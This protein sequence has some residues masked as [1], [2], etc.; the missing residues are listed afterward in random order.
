MPYALDLFSPA[1]T[2]GACP[3]FERGG[4]RAAFSR[5]ALDRRRV[6]NYCA[7]EDHD[8]CPFYLS[9][10]LRSTRLRYCGTRPGDFSG[11]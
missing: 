4:C 10:V 8:L 6:Q 1:A 9:K 11:K 5:Q 2:T 3:Y 7:C